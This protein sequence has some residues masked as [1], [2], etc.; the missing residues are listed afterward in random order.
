MLEQASDWLALAQ[1][2]NLRELNASKN[3]F[4]TIPATTK[5][6]FPHLQWINIAHNRISDESDLKGL[7]SCTRLFCIVLH[8]NPLTLNTA[9]CRSEVTI[10]G[11]VVSLVTDP[12]SSS[13]ADDVV[14]DGTMTS[15]AY[16]GSYTSFQMCKNL[17]RPSPTRRQKHHKTPVSP[18][19]RL[20]ASRK[21][22]SKRRHHQQPLSPGSSV[23]DRPSSTSKKKKK[24]FMLNSSSS[25]EVS[26]ATVAS[27]VYNTMSH[28]LTSSFE[29]T[30]KAK[31]S[32]RAH[33]G[34]MTK[35]PSKFRNAM[36]S[37][38]AKLQRPM[39]T[40]AS[41]H[42]QSHQFEKSTL[43]WNKKSKKKSGSTTEN[44]ESHLKRKNVPMNVK[45][46][47][48]RSIMSSVEKAIHSL[49]DV[50][51]GD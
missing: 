25:S 4:K 35:D 49:E 30:M 51:G 7:M 44:Y 11:R 50:D 48:T 38:R 5:E 31:L 17:Q 46:K 14:K 32:Q 20:R 26:D 28:Q 1:I 18:V 36:S 15:T 43:S 29:D 39:T 6:S 2:P 3:E 40:A 27:R 47:V 24:T 21:H 41:F 45:A 33:H 19:E 42:L 37:L 34:G 23:L 8:D 9:I 22:N 16:T 12:P 13:S 10:N